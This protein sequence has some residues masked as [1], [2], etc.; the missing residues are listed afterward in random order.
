M[1][2]ELALHNPKF[3]SRIC[4][5]FFNLQNITRR[6]LDLK[7]NSTTK[8]SKYPINFAIK[9][10]IALIICMDRIGYNDLKEYS[11]SFHVQSSRCAWVW[12]LANKLVQYFPPKKIKFSRLFH[13]KIDQW[14]SF[15]RK[16]FR[17]VAYIDYNVFIF[18]FLANGDVIVTLLPINTKWPW[19]TPAIFR[20]ELVPE[21]LMAHCLTVRLRCA[22][23]SAILFS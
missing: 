16:E 19:I 7:Q 17:I 11:F 1:K 5:S 23:F 18:Q 2:C 21:E 6:F 12:Q 10:L 14:K 4:I 15:Y 20:P 22:I 9:A 3:L 8:M 13:I